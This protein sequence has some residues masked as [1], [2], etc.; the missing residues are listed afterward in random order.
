MSELERL[1]NTSGLLDLAYLL[2]CTPKGLSYN[3]YELSPDEKYRRFDIPKKSGGSRTINAPNERLAL[4]QQRLASLL[5]DCIDEIQKKNK[6]YLRASHAFQKKRTIISNAIQHRR[7]RYVFNIDLEDF[8]GTINFGRV[9]GFFIKD[10]NFA[11][12]EPVATLIAQIACHENALPQ[13]SPCS[14]V[15]SNLIGHILDRRI[16]ALARDAKCTYTRYADDLTFSTNIKEFPT[17]IAVNTDGAEWQVGEMLRSQIDRAGFS[18]NESKTRMALRHS[19][20][21]VTG[22]V[23]NAKVNIN[24]NYYRS[25]RAMCR[26]LLRTGQYHNPLAHNT[27]VEDGNEDAREGIDNLNPLE[28]MLAHIYY[29]KMR[30]DRWGDKDTE[31]SKINKRAKEAGEFKPP[32]A[33]GNLYENFLF[34][35]H[36]AIPPAPLIVCEGKTDI[37]YLKCAIHARASQFPELADIEDNTITRKVRFLKRSG[38]ILH[39]FNLASGTSGQAALIKKYKKTIEKFK[40]QPM[41]HPV[42]I[43]CDNDDGSK[44]VFKAFNAVTE[45]TRQ[46]TELGISKDSTEKFYYLFKNLY[47]VKIPESTEKG[48]IEELFP[49]GLLDIKLEGKSLKLDENSNQSET[50]SKQVFAEKIVRPKRGDAEVFSNFDSLLGRIKDCISDYEA[51]RRNQATSLII[52]QSARS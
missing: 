46:D 15:I 5:Y 17:E 1:K 8:F 3:L 25:V 28:G 51:R 4:I 19:R 24:Q 48:Y 47:L 39:T 40:H 26:S 10:T 29:V 30:R 41:E 34:Y 13:G 20:Q 27:S 16:S 12:A 23:V 2:S 44:C 32:K 35:K 50:Y 14:P 33:I 43:L 6:N 42:I 37:T 36:F 9:R 52:S 18:I 45:N 7:R 31:K 38:S 49:S 11:V 21:T 22:L